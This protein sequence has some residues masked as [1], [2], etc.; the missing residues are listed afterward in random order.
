MWGGEKAVYPPSRTFQYVREGNAPPRRRVFSPTLPK[1]LEPSGG[2][3]QVL[4]SLQTRFT[5]DN[6][7]ASS[8]RHIASAFAVRYNVVG[9]G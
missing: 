9:R 3:G 2:N 8:L 5:A 1:V 6:A 7:N 4:P